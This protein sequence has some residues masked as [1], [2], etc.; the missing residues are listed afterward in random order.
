MAA[1][2]LTASWSC[3]EALGGDRGPGVLLLWGSLHW[4]LVRARCH[5]LPCVRS[6][7]SR[8]VTGA[9][10][11]LGGR[12]GAGLVHAQAML[13]WWDPGRPPQAQ[14]HIERQVGVWQGGR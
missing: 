9:R 6:P 12:R 14:M 2:S 10:A 1:A 5:A 11:A 4:A 3:H 7:C 8:E 13:L